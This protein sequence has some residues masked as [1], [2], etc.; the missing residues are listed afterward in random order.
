M[1]KALFLENAIVWFEA[2]IILAL[3]S[4][5]YHLYTSE[6]DERLNSISGNAD[7][8]LFDDSC[9]HAPILDI[10]ERIDDCKGIT[11]SANTELPNSKQFILFLT[12][13]IDEDNFSRRDLLEEEAVIIDHTVS[14]ESY[15]FS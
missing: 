7:P 8:L 11:L 12:L 3:L 2:L 10:G 5:T 14:M 13:F 6:G 15:L 4:Y 1:M 9:E